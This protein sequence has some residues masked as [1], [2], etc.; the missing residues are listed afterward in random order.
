MSRLAIRSAATLAALLA[1]AACGAPHTSTSVLPSNTQLAELRRPQ[2]T[3]GG[4][5]TFDVDVQIYD[6]PLAN[7]AHVNLAVAGVEA[8]SGS[9]A[10]PIATYATPQV[11]DLLA[12]QHQAMAIAGTLPVGNYH[13]IRL[14]VDT[15]H[16]NVVGTDGT[17]YPMH[18]GR[19]SR[20]NPAF[21]SLDA[22]AHVNGTAGASVSLTLDFNVLESISLNGGVAY[23]DPKLIIA[24][25][26][27]NVSG[28]IVN[29]AGA[30][31]A[32]ATVTA[33][34]ADGDL[35]NVTITGPDGTFAL[36]ALAA[37]SYTIAVANS[38]TTPFGETIEAIGNDK[39]AAPS[40]HLDLAPGDHID[41]GTLID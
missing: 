9:T 22:S 26:A 24:R 16:S 38:S 12:L 33:S 2:D 17:V 27:A 34:D 18:F 21:V 1:L 23:V 36:H 39:G 41:L 5:P 29:A 13:A 37:G 31:V 28:K 3:L 40:V 7:A 10:H 6:A 4:A 11:V 35:M 19:W 30:P 20:W 14:V 25:G 15:S 8:V 32:F